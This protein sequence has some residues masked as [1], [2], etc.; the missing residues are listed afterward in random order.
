M[1]GL[2]AHLRV[3]GFIR[4]CLGSLSATTV[5]RVHWGLHGFTQAQLGS[6]RFIRFVMGS[7][8]RTEVLPSS[9]GITW[10]NS[11]ASMGRRNYSVSRGS[12]RCHCD[13]RVFTRARLWV[14]GCILVRDGSLRHV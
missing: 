12:F 2:A 14:S 13:S 9:F 10:V 3:S 1:V 8:G 6:A 4:V 11:G 5:R 7:F